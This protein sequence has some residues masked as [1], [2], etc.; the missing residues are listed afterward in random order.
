MRVSIK[1]EV[2]LLVLFCGLELASMEK[3]VDRA[4]TSN[5]GEVLIRYGIF[6]I[7]SSLRALLDGDMQ[8]IVGKGDHVWGKEHVEAL[9]NIC[10]M[11]TGARFEDAATAEIEGYG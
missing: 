2:S 4:F 1:C 10:P 5:F 6:V 11:L 3:F 8:D 7:A 9:R